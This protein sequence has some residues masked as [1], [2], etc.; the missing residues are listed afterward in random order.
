LVE[1]KFLRA[2]SVGFVPVK[3]EKLNA[4]ASD[5]SGPFRFL[6]SQ[7]LEVSLVSVPAN[8]NAVAL[9]RSLNP[10]LVGA[11]FSKPA[12]EARAANP[13]SL[14]N[15]TP[16]IRGL[17]MQLN[18]TLASRIDAAQ[19]NVMALRTR[20]DEI[21]SRQLMMNLPCCGYLTESTAEVRCKNSCGRKT[22]TGGRRE[23]NVVLSVG[24]TSIEAVKQLKKS[25]A[26]ANSVLPRRL[27]AAAVRLVQESAD[28]W[29]YVPPLATW[30]AAHA[31]RE[32]IDHVLRS[33]YGDRDEKMNIVLRAAVNPATT[34]V[35]GW[36]A[37]LVQT[38]N[39]GFLDR[40][41]PKSIY[42]PL[43]NRGNRY[44]FGPGV[45]QLK[46]PVRTT[47]ALLSGAWVGEGAAK[48]VKKASFINPDPIHA[49]RHL[50]LY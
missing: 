29:D 34:T 50:D 1:Q 38:Q 22:I 27:R 10:D 5:Y 35:A 3:R 25:S 4:D 33:R 23:G 39:A 8:A 19:K 14:P 30:F 6:K 41:L 26:P 42:M 12:N 7:L 36:A 31:S 18:Q 32:T 17:S 47:T 49:G 11:I 46:I 2:T 20:L 15:I 40:I 9:A 13:A 24:S 21:T 45:S 44:T 28:R 48:P 16:R 43:A 37:E